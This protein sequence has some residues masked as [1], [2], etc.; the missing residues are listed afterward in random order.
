MGKVAYILVTLTSYCDF[1][2]KCS[3]TSF[4]ENKLIIDLNWN[5]RDCSILKNRGTVQQTDTVEFL[6][7]ERKCRQQNLTTSGPIREQILIQRNCLVLCHK[8]WLAPSTTLP[9]KM[10]RS[11]R[12]T[13]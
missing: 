10:A 11:S 12:R 4:S 9:P 7:D 3:N 2:F 5:C 13:V 1:H 6:I 8:G